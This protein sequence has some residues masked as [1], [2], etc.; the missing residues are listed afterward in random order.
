M[1]FSVRC[2][3]D[4]RW[5]MWMIYLTRL[6]G[7]MAIKSQIFMRAP[8]AAR[9]SS[10]QA[11]LWPSFYFLSSFIR[12]HP[13]FCQAQSYMICQRIPDVEV[14][15]SDVTK[16]TKV[17]LVADTLFHTL[18]AMSVGRSLTFLGATK[19]LYNWLCPSVCWSVCRSVTHRS[20]IHTSHILA[21]LAL[22]FTRLI[23]RQSPPPLV[24]GKTLLVHI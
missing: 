8:T 19:H 16:R 11:Q 4:C 1:S 22:F 7:K 24:E 12:V 20:T 14:T 10:V 9:H 5:S 6:Q 21:Y 18:L 23:A 17:F 15:F 2:I 13:F 3:R